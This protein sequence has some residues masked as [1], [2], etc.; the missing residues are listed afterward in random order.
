M[1]RA[2]DAIARIKLPLSEPQLTNMEKIE[3]KRGG[4][5][6]ILFDQFSSE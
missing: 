6:R 5:T 4:E 2:R 3:E 1:E